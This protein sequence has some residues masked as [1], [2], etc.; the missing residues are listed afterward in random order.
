MDDRERIRERN[1]IDAAHQENA[2][3]FIDV[4]DTDAVLAAATYV[5]DEGFTPM[6]ALHLVR[7][8]TDAI[9]SSETDYDGVSDRLELEADA[10]DE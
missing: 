8:E 7:S 4:S 3:G 6:D 10:N 2:T 1:R 9:V 5:E